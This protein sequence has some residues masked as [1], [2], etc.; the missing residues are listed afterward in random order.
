MT[1]PEDISNFNFGITYCPAT[2]G[3]VRL[4]STSEGLV[5]PALIQYV[6][7]GIVR[8]SATKK[9]GQQHTAWDSDPDKNARQN[10]ND[11]K[12][13]VESMKT[14]DLCNA[15]LTFTMQVRK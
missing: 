4:L 2:G 3:S 11:F 8:V 9:G 7:H 5:G 6:D 12:E 15:E 10:Q 14:S 13:F 1:L